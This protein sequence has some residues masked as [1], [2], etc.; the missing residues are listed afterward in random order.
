MNYS[1]LVKNKIVNKAAAL[2]AGFS[3]DPDNTQALVLCRNLPNGLVVTLKLTETTLDVDVFDGI[4]NERYAP[5]YGG[6]GGA[7]IKSEVREIV[8][9]ALSKCTSSVDVKSRI[10]QWLQDTYGTVPENP[11]EDEP[12]YY[13][14]KTAK[15]AKWYA[16][17]M[18]IAP[19]F[20]S[21]EG[22]LPVQV[23]NLK[24]DPSTV[25]SAVDNRRI[26]PAYHM[27]KQHWITVL[28]N[29]ST[30][31]AELKNLLSASYLLA[32]GKKSKK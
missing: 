19:K 1:Y 26:F 11:W 10:M 22:D 28:L 30:D 15:S 27:N 18:D 5:F 17:F 20:L 2:S 25:A 29:A 32:D 8:E 21:L 4:F 12:T 31:V 9:Q 6:H 3:L 13:T 16:L 23:V 24:A 14:F 7:A